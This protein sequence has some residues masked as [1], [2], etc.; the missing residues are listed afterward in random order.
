MIKA[1]RIHFGTDDGELDPSIQTNP[2]DPRCFAQLCQH[3]RVSSLV[4]HNLRRTGEPLYRRYETDLAQAVQANAFRILSYTSGLRAWARWFEAEHIPFFLLKGLGL[5]HQYYT[6]PAMRSC[7]DLDLW[8]PPSEVAR[9]LKQATSMGYEPVGFQGQMKPRERAFYL[10]HYPDLGFCQKGPIPIQLELHWKLDATEKYFSLPFA[11]LHHRAE[12]VSIN[13]VEVPTLPLPE[14]YQYLLAHGIKHGWHRL[15]W[16]VDI[17]TVGASLPAHSNDLTAV[18][19]AMHD[20]HAV[21]H[22]LCQTL[23]HLTP[24][25][26]D[27]VT[28]PL[29]ARQRVITRWCWS[30]ITQALPVG[31]V[32]YKLR[33]QH[34]QLQIRSEAKSRF[35]WIKMQIIGVQ[36]FRSFK[37]PDHLF[38]LYLIFRPFFMLWRSIKHRWR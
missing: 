4:A 38:F 28:L 20:A 1:L 24:G 27:G 18:G 34:Y 15:F 11:A 7:G 25:R 26:G 3:H 17:P 12:S 10:R 36:D 14:G 33:H 16:L 13:G 19:Y 21:T 8:I 31:S 35:D 6:P 22:H 2:P 9:T 5:A 32:L 29:T 37:L 30:S 23:F